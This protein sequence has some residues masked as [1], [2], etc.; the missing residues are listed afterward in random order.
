MGKAENRRDITK[1]EPVLHKCL[2]RPSRQLGGSFGG[3]CGMVSRVS[4]CGDG[5]ACPGGKVD[6]RDDF[7]VRSA[8][9]GE[10]RS[11]LLLCGAQ[12]SAC[13]VDVR[14]LLHEGTPEKI[15]LALVVRGEP[16]H[17][18]IVPLSNAVASSCTIQ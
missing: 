9:L 5:L 3:L 16:F 13:S 1:A 8:V 18:A 14:Y 11:Q 4:G 17:V 10:C 15:L 2:R 7:G 12:A 6:E